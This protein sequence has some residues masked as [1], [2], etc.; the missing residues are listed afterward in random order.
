MWS[1]SVRQGLEKVTG[2]S[3][4]AYDLAHQGYA[5]LWTSTAQLMQRRLSAKRDLRLPQELAKL[6]RYTCLVL[7]DIGY[8]QVRRFGMYDIAPKGAEG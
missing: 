6:H 3:A 8:V 5:V 7:D 2:L 1:P 4:V